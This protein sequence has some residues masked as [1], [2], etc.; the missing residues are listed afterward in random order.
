MRRSP[1][2]SFYLRAMGT[3]IWEELRSQYDLNEPVPDRLTE[4]L[5]ELDEGQE[6]T[7]TKRP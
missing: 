6:P 2:Y 5:K 7:A 3:N 1:R 4:L